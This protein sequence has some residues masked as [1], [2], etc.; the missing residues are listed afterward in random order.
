MVGQNE[1]FGGAATREELRMP[2]A[3]P[4]LPAER[5]QREF[6][7]IGFFLSGHPLDDYA[8]ILERLKVQRWTTFCNSVKQGATAGRVAG[9]VVSRAER[10]TKTGN[11]MGILGILR[12]VRPLRSGDLPGRPDAVPRSA[13]ARQGGAADADR[14]GAGRGRARAYPDRRAAR[15]RGG[16]DAE[17]LARVRQF[18]P[19]DR[20]R[21]QAA[22]AGARRPRDPPATKATPK[23]RWC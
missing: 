3:Q 12:S 1:L 15:C 20:K 8:A 17:G 14:G 5:L 22:R 4:W 11:K 18:G 7:A 23:S 16:E 6:D 19:A 21:C 13:R 10:R 9:T 2:A